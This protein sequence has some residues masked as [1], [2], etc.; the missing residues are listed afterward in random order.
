VVV[1]NSFGFGGV[2]TSL[3]LRPFGIPGANKDGDVIAENEA[4]PAIG[5][6]PQLLT[7][8]GRTEEGV[9]STLSSVS[10]FFSICIC[11]GLFA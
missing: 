10:L 11:Y 3:V 9:Q 4:T 2:N 7:V 6:F 8:S 1:L 5:S